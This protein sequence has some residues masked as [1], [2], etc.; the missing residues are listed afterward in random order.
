MGAKQL[1]LQFQALEARSVEEIEVAFRL[2]ARERA[3][4]LIVVVDA[5]FNAQQEGISDLGIKDRLPTMFDNGQ[6]VQAGGL[7]SVW[8]QLIRYVPARGDLCG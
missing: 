3:G 5:L 2:A 7:I 1:G 4:A 8:R 6:Y